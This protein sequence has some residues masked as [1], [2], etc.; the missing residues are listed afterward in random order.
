MKTN[1]FI[2]FFF[3]FS[4]SLFGDNA[5][6]LRERKDTHYL[7]K[8]STISFPLDSTASPLITALEYNENND[9][10]SFIYRKSLFCYKYSSQFFLG[11]TDIPSTHPTTYTYVNEDSIFANDYSKKTIVRFNKKGELLSSH[12]VRFP[13]KYSGFP[14]AKTSS[15]VY[16]NGAI[17]FSGNTS[18]EIPF[19]NSKNRNVLNKIDLS[20]N[21]TKSCLSYTEM[22]NK[23]NWGGGLFRW[24]Y[25]DY[26]NN[27]EFV[28]SLPAEHYIYVVSSDMEQIRKYYAGSNFFSNIQ[29]LK[30]SKYL[31][32]SNE[33]S[34]KHF[35][36]T[37]SYS[38]IIYDKYRNCYYR[39][40]E[41]KTEYNGQPT[42][43][44]G[45]SIIIL[46]DKFEIIGE[47]LI[48]KSGLLFRFGMFVTE[49]GLHIPIDDKN[50]ETLNFRIYRL[51]QK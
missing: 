28:V 4:C 2:I 7:E 14:I 8:Y 18:G 13:S 31:D 43:Q 26:N 24:T 16:N 42:W 32:V 9:I 48:E 45:L 46:N 17:Y 50:K 51:G 34:T 47:T 35:V 19:E 27:D 38:N 44:K 12:R 23:H 20:T 49:K 29:Y 36:E 25:S 21:K 30:K 6:K 15:M 39:M 33:A 5:N 22:Y 11:K 10:F 3:F 41:K 1:A 40:A 37:N